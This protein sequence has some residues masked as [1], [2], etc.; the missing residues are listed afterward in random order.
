M[1]TGRDISEF[2]L[3]HLHFSYDL[4][5][6]ESVNVTGLNAVNLKIAL[7]EIHRKKKEM[8]LLHDIILFCTLQRT[9]TTFHTI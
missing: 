9:Y 7:F 6:K 1:P 3:R 4:A 5:I 2:P 8:L